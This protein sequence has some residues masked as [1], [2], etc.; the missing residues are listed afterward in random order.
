MASSDLGLR[1]RLVEVRYGAPGI[2]LYRLASLDGAMLQAFDNGELDAALVL[3]FDA[4][5]WR[6]RA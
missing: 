3:R 5:A 6:S 2:N 1:L 4:S